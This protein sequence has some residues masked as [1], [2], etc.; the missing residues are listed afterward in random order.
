MR[1]LQDDNSTRLAG[2]LEVRGRVYRA[3]GD[4]DE[5]ERYLRQGLAIRSRVQGDDNPATAWSRVELAQL[6]QE[7]GR[8]GRGPGNWS[9]PP[10][11]CWSRPCRRTT[12]GLSRP[13]SWTAYSSDPFRLRPPG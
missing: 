7:Q 2:A 3:A 8:T 11:R 6:L 5:A 9:A 4:L 1:R 13:G 10:D 12:T